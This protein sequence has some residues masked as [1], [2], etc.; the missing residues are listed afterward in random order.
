MHGQTQIK[1]PSNVFYIHKDEIRYLNRRFARR[2]TRLKNYVF[3]SHGVFLRLI[4]PTKKGGHPMAKF[5]EA[6]R[7]SRKVACST[8]SGPLGPG[9]DSDSKRNKYHEYLLEVKAAG[10]LTLS[11]TE[12]LEIWEP[13]PTGTLRA[14]PGIA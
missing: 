1:F 6:L 10:V 3:Y 13:Q 2:E 12:Y 14:C 8:P 7:Y 11:C 9:V 4:S 5:V